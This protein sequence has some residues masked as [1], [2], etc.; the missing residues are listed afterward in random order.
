MI[1]KI[2]SILNDG[3]YHTAKEIAELL[4]ISD[5]TS[6]KYIKE[7]NSLLQKKGTCIISK[8]KCGFMLKGNMLDENDLFS[9]KNKEMPNSSNERVQYL[10]YLLLKTDKYNKLEQISKDIY[11]STK[12]LSKDMKKV[13][14]IVKKYS[15]NILRKPYY[16]IK[17]SGKEFSKRNLLIDVLENR[18]NENKTIGNI[19]GIGIEE[20]G[21][22]TNQFFKENNVKISDVYFQNFILATFVVL[23]RI[24]DN[25]KIELIESYE[26]FFVEKE[27]VIKTYLNLIISKFNL[28]I[29][30]NENDLKYLVIRFFTNESLNYKNYKNKNVE[31]INNLIKDIYFYIKLTFNINLNNDEILYDNLYIHLLPLIIR[32]KFNIIIKNPLLKEI[33]Q[34]LAFEYSIAKYICNYLE[35]IYNKKISEDEIGYIAL[36]LNTSEKI[37]QISTNN[38][39]NI[40]IICPTGK[41]VS[42][43]LIHTYKNLF[44]K[45]CNFVNSCSLNE[46]ND[47]D[48]DTYDFIFTLTDIN[49]NIKKPVY[50]INHFL[51]SADIKRIE[52]ILSID[53]NFIENIFPKKLFIIEDKNINKITS[54]KNMSLKIKENF[55]VGN[56]KIEKEFLEREKLGMTEM[57]DL[58]AIP[59]PRNSLQN[60]NAIGVYILKKP[61]LWNKNKVKLVLFLCLDNVNYKN[62]IVYTILS[63]II[64]N[65]NIV[66]EIIKVKSYE[67]F[68][69]II[70][71]V[72]K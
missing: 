17:L 27:Q 64:E 62:E 15:L 12:T 57:G 43:F 24:L 39:K 29:R 58:I 8:P 2:Y 21:E 19:N 38:K 36:I 52:A 11:V 67:E 1:Y 55:N 48:L 47:I 53:N 23:Y 10:L 14:E 31:N 7:L 68:I 16:G 46:I 25:K 45:Y 60:I 30:F 51:N 71:K 69:E 5:R 44:S 32:I 4:Q 22:F 59:H 70:R 28:N 33:K 40:L 26:D 49:I 37:N 18:I 34:N 54:I 42:K 6:R 20:I 56:S 72:K 66:N 3:T 13:E 65:E 35:K 61:I 41:G 50:K 9:N 63:R